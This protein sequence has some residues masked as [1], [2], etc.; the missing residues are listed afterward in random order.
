M[1][2][3]T[4]FLQK[5]NQGQ[6]SEIEKSINIGIEKNY[7]CYAALATKTNGFHVVVSLFSY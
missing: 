5:D 2:K 4:N 7:H 1:I 6:Q 3:N